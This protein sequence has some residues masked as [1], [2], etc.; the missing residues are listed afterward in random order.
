[1]DWG[2]IRNEKKNTKQLDK[3]K[4]LIFL[5][6]RG[7]VYNVWICKRYHNSN[8]KGLEKRRDCIWLQIFYIL[9]EVVQSSQ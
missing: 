9:I 4:R 3:Y 8:I 6:K 5:F 2:E 7:K 1:M